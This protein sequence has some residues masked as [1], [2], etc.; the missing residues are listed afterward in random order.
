MNDRDERD[1]VAGRARGRPAALRRAVDWYRRHDRLA[2]RG[3][4]HHGR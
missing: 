3:R 2:H 4:G 1:R